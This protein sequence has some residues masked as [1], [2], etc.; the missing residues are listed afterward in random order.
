M[1]YTKQRDRWYTHPV[2]PMFTRD[3]KHIEA[4]AYRAHELG[5]FLAG[6]VVGACLTFGVAVYWGWL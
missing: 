6:L 2:A 5:D 1:I 3:L 4:Q